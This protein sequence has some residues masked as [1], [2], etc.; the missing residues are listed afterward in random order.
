MGISPT[1]RKVKVAGISFQRI[2]DGKIQETRN[3]WDA[4][5]MLQQL[6]VVPELAAKER[7]AFT[8]ALRRIRPASARGARRCGLT[9]SARAARTF[10]GPQSAARR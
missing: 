9:F 1:N 2:R 5:G 10:S 4:L 3:L 6:G 7:Q 8:L